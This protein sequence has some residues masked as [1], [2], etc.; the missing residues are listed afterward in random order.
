MKDEEYLIRLGEKIRKLRKSKN[1]TQVELAERLGTKHPQLVRVE[2]GEANSTINM[3]RK[4]AEELGV[5][6]SDL[7]KI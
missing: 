7:V 5:S 2:K 6:V 3:L 4:I 1:L